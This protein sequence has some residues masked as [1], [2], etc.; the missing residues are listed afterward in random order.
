MHEHTSTL[1]VSLAPCASSRCD[2]GRAG[3]VARR[4]RVC[5]PACHCCW[6]QSAST[7]AL[8]RVDS[9]VRQRS[10]SPRDT[11]LESRCARLSDTASRR[12]AL[13]ASTTTH[14]SAIGTKSCCCFQAPSTL[15]N[16]S[17]PRI[18]PLSVRARRA[19]ATC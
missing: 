17:K 5:L 18:D 9:R 12:P 7:V 16:I 8:R 15:F 10:R 11:R 1:S 6:P 19:T 4:A 2:R 13:R 14:T 3:D